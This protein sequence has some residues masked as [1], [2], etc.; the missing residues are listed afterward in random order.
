[1]KVLLDDRY[2]QDSLYRDKQLMYHPNPTGD[3]LGKAQWKWLE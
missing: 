1:M 3:V 2:F